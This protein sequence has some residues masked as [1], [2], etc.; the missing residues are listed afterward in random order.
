MIFRILFFIGIVMIA[1]FTPTWLFVI[2]L[3][4]YALSYTSYELI[5][6]GLLLDGL[7][8]ASSVH[9]V[10]YYTLLMLTLVFCAQWVKP[11]ISRYNEN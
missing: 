7:Y 4:A 9:L 10:P 3:C 11:S 6:L 8:G 5:F 2:A 1:L